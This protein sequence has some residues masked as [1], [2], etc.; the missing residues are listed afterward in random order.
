MTTPNEARTKK[1]LE[2]AAGARPD[3]DRN[4]HSGKHAETVRESLDEIKSAVRNLAEEKLEQ[5]R[6][7]ASEV[8]E[9]GRHKVQRVEQGFIETIR[10]KPIRS[11]LIAT[12]IG[13]LL[14]R[15]WMRR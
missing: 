11:V 12:G 6:D 15:F 8:G 14:G 13:M 4:G 7:F 3:R 5:A 1:N 2:G 10:T 9:Q